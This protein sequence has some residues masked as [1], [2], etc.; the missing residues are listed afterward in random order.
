MAKFCANCGFQMDDEDKVCG[1]CGTPFAGAQ[2]A[3]AQAAPAQVAPAQTAPV[4]TAEKP[5]KDKGGNKIIMIVVAAIAFIIVAVIAVNIIGSNTGYKGTLNKMVKALQ[6]NDIASLE[7]MASSVS[8]ETYTSWYGKDMYEHYDESISNTLDK[9]EDNVGKIKKITY[10]ISDEMEFSDRRLEETKDNL[11]DSYNMDVSGLKKI[12]KV[13]LKVT[14]KGTK[15]SATYS[16]NNLY[17]IKE[18]GG[19]KLYYGNLNY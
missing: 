4:Q 6:Q 17:L 16:V 7:A 11:I 2:A 3:P 9:Y 1:Q 14:V 5:A 18:S 12:L 8:D 10:E 19:W 13:S 15:K